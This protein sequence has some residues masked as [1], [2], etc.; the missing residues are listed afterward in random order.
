[1]ATLAVISLPW[2]RNLDMGG[3]LSGVKEA[4]EWP[5][6]N[7]ELLI[8]IFAILAAYL[9]QGKTNGLCYDPC[10]LS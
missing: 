9:L 6:V 5:K 2:Y 10:I 7:G 4:S 3:V 1:M 8:C